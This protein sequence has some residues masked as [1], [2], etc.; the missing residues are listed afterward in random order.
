MMAAQL[1]SLVTFAP[2]P[3]RGANV[4]QG[5]YPM[6]KRAYGNPE[7]IPF[8]VCAQ[9]PHVSGVHRRHGAGEP[10]HRVGSV[11]QRGVLLI[12]GL[13]IGTGAAAADLLQPANTPLKRFGFATGPEMST[14]GEVARVYDVTRQIIGPGGFVRTGL[15]W[16]VTR[17]NVPDFATWSSLKL[18]PARARG[19]LVLPRISTHGPGGYR[20]PTDAQWTLG[21]RQI[22]RMYGP[23]GVY[24]KGGTYVRNGRTVRVAAHPGFAGI[25][26]YELW[27]EPDSNGDVGGAMT[28][29]KIAR[30]LK[31][32]SAVMRAEAAL[33]G[34]RI[35]IIGPGF[36]G[37]EVAD[38]RKLWEADNTIF[39]SI[40]TLSVHA[41]SRSSVST[42]NPAK[43][44]V[45]CINNLVLIRNFLDTHGGAHVHLA[46]SEG[47]YA[48]DKGIC[49]G[50]Q[51]LTEEQQ[52]AYSE[53]ALR[54]VRARP[55]LDIDFWAIYHP[56]DGTRKYGYACDSGRYD[57][58]YYKE[59][60]GVVRADSTMKPLGTRL[61]SLSSEWW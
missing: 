36:D 55:Y 34:F 43:E 22:V 28:P 45:R 53:E 18:E 30:L 10:R 11:L 24:A 58:A 57:N 39:R 15:Q 29:A 19:L 50:P 3:G 49:R 21:L 54:W 27:N 38:V 5:E 32:G 1:Q 14:P 61:R 6:E 33:L 13:L 4:K 8:N 46:N 37:I 20:I 26:D 44:P 41:Y 35:N 16:D 23:G 40:D 31:I 48:G 56:I 12:A 9:K 17:F 60:L 25:T 2:K 51:V 52:A 47:G 42:C 59:K 7:S